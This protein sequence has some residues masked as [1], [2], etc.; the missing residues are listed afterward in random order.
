LQGKA[1]NEIHAIVTETLG[2]HV[3]F[4]ATVKSWMVQF[5]R[6]DFS[7]CNAPH[8]GRPK[9]V[10]IPEIIHQIHELIL[11]DRKPDFG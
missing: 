3:A 8:P 5:K 9:T 2:E 10:T 11:E 6:G 7:N 4:Y 1:S